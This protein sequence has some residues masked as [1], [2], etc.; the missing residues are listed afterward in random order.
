VP[1]AFQQRVLYWGILGAIIMRGLMI[2]AGVALLDRLAWVTYV[3]GAFLLL[4]GFRLL[5]RRA[6]S[7]EQGR[8]SGILRIVARFVPVTECRDAA[9][10]RRVNGRVTVTPLFIAL[11]V[12]EVSDAMFATDS[13]P[14]VF[15][16]TRDPFLVYTSNMLAVLGLRSMYFLV[17]GVLPRLRYLRFGL[18]AILVFVGAKMLASSVV[19]IPIWLS[20]T[21]IVVAIGVATAASLLGSR[22][23]PATSTAGEDGVELRAR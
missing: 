14:A 19:A 5:R 23:A 8:G 12:I 17:A 22:P 4:A 21:V 11:V 1:T 3:F 7:A 6:G 10:F 15:G 16:V 20:L 2:A 13:L 9:F 18:A